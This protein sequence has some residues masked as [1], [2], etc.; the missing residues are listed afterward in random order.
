MVSKKVKRVAGKIKRLEIQGASR[1][2]KA[3]IE[4]LKAS[5]LEMWR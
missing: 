2:R 1:V 3:V 5:I 4:A